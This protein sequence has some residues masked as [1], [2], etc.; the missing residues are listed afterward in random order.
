MSID[1]LRPN[2]VKTAS[3]SDGKWLTTKDE[4]GRKFLSEIVGVIASLVNM[5]LEKQPI[6]RNTRRVKKQN[7]DSS[8][9][10]SEG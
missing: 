1:M 8:V 5:K 4:E 7:L 9:R 10:F 3:K 6:R 2:L